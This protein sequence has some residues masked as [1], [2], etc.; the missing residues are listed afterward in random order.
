MSSSFPVRYHGLGVINS[1]LW[2][3]YHCSY[4]SAEPDWHAFASSRFF[5]RSVNVLVVNAIFEMGFVSIVYFDL[6][7]LFHF[8][9]FV[10]NISIG[11]EL[12]Y[13]VI[14]FVLIDVDVS[15]AL[16]EYYVSR[17]HSTTGLINK[18]YAKPCVSREK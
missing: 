10:L 6:F 1:G 17:F 7:C 13:W 15:F 18:D 16:Y 9:Q 3:V 5:F 11:F 12:G 8:M 4:G 14:N 2:G